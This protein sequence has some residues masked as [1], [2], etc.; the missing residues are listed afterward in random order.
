MG[1]KQHLSKM[2]AA[3]KVMYKNSKAMVANSCK[4]A[5]EVDANAVTS[6]A[7]LDNKYKKRGQSDVFGKKSKKHYHF[8]GEV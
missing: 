2:I 6:E 7:K 8:I 5:G 3:E 4:G 1:N